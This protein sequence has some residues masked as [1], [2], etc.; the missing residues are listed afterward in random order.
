M[1]MSARC[2]FISIIVPTRNSEKTI[3]ECMH[4]LVN[5]DYPRECY[6]IIV[7]DAHS[8]DMTV[9]I[10]RS[11]GARILYEEGGCRASACNVG[12]PHALGDFIAFTDGDCIVPPGWLKTALKY[13]GDREV[14]GVG[15]PNIVPA[16][17]TI[18]AKA[19]DFVI[20]QAIFSANA[21]YARKL[22]EPTEVIS[23]AGCNAVYRAGALKALLPLAETQAE[24]A[25]LN[26]RLRQE[27]YKIIDAPDVF[28]WH[29]RHWNSAPGLFRQMV[30]YAKGRVQ[31][32]RMYPE[33]VRPVHRLVGFSLPVAAIMAVVLY[34]LS[35]PV[36][37]SVIGLGVVLLIFFSVKC[38]Y[39]TRS[40]GI[41]VRVPIAIVVEWV[42][43]SVG[44]IKETLQGGQR[45]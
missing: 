32:G 4:S 21:T 31:A 42:G 16:D 33:M 7:V 6:E 12:I 3:A 19:V 43:W 17:V 11:Y 30:T 41:A 36:L 29:R 25:V 39:Q 22:G 20:S 15:G 9:A 2:S 1:D 18:F 44:Y 14:V 26:H 38:L 40:S 37:L 28:V 10:A 27:G 5:L 23:I 8:T 35:W 13:F 45:A 34:L 24:D